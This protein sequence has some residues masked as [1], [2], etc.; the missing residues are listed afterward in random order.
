MLINDAIFS[1]I[2]EK[3]SGYLDAAIYKEMYQ[4]SCNLM[5]EIIVDIG[6]AQGASTICFA[7]AAKKK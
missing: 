6:P 2:K 7:L 1:S 4:I 5:D 3:T